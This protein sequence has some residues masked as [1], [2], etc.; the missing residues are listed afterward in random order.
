MRCKV[1]F[2]TLFSS[3]ILSI[4]IDNPYSYIDSIED[5]EKRNDLQPILFVPDVSIDNFRNDPKLETSMVR[6]L[7][8][9]HQY[10]LNYD[11]Y[12]LLEKNIDQ[13]FENV[14]IKQSHILLAS[15]YDTELMLSLN[16]IKYGKITHISRQHYYDMIYG[17][18]FRKDMNR[19]VAQTFHQV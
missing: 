5:L 10:K 8:N 18:I 14:S 13:I 6:A 16:K 17:Y 9:D 12:E 3:E 11:F 15:K 7:A 2:L 1:I 4:N 19:F